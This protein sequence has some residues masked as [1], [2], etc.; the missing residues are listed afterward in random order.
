MKVRKYKRSR[1]DVVLEILQIIDNGEGTPTR[2]MYK[3][4]LSWVPLNNLLKILTEQGLI[5][6]ERNKYYHSWN[7][8]IMEKGKKVMKYFADVDVLNLREALK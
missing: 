4:N 2:I 1:L 8:R 3:S 5:E 7:Y 6:K